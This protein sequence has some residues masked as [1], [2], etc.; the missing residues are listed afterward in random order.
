MGGS[1]RRML[2]PALAL[3]G[4]LTVFALDRPALAQAPTTRVRGVIDAIVGSN[5]DVATR[6]GMVALRIAETTRLSAVAKAALEDIKPG[7]YVG[8]AAMPQPDGSQIALEVVV[9]PEALRGAGEG[10]RPWD[11]APESTMTNATVADTV[12][13]V[14]GRT[15]TLTYKDGRKAILLPP[16]IPIVTLVPATREDLKPGVRIFSNATTAADGVRTA[17]S[18]VVGRDGVEPPM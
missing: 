4:L 11:L 8:I 14:E 13:K 1:L 3:A 15:L 5:L 17:T 10:H 6:D 18:V 7:S 9:F 12:S 16:E 2:V